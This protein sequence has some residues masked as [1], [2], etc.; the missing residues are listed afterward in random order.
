MC[1]T[2]LIFNAHCE[3]EHAEIQKCTDIIASEARWQRKGFFSKM[4]SSPPRSCKRPQQTR[5][6]TK[7][8]VCPE[9]SYRGIT[10]EQLRKDRDSA[11]RRPPR[12]I[13]REQTDLNIGNPVS[14]PDL[15]RSNA[16][17]RLADRRPQSRQRSNAVQFQGEAPR[18]PNV[19][20]SAIYREPQ[21]LHPDTLRQYLGT[22]GVPFEAPGITAY[23]RP[24]ISSSEN[25][26]HRSRARSNSR[27]LRPGAPHPHDNGSSQYMDRPLPPAP[28]RPHRA[29]MNPTST[30]R[31]PPVPTRSSSQRPSQPSR[32]WQSDLSR[33]SSQRHPQSF[34]QWQPDISPPS[35]QSPSQSSGEQQLALTRYVPQGPSHAPSYHLGMPTDR[36]LNRI[37]MEIESVESAWIN[38]GRRTSQQQPVTRQSTG[39]LTAPRRH[40]S[41]REGRYA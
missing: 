40:R 23:Q 30:P 11:Q 4:F 25:R 36:E 8:Q 27:Q 7:T 12:P 5:N 26:N 17:R 37:S 35:S 28:L 1:R 24:P 33:S 18:L 6:Y 19:R 34:S 41:Q 31:P 9:C 2:I 15:Q 32:R 3:H 14:P 20:A 29:T 39:S 16:M 38:A 10:Y 21:N 13:Y 22:S